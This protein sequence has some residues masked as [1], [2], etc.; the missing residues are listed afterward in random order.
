M[1]DLIKVLYKW[2][3]VFGL[4]FLNLFILFSVA[5]AIPSLLVIW[6]LNPVLFRVNPRIL[7]LSAKL[8]LLLPIRISSGLLL[9]I[10]NI[11][12]LFSF[13]LIFHLF[14]YLLILSISQLVLIASALFDGCGYSI[15]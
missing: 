13:V 9:D 10:D 11:L 2:L 5:L 4:R 6:I 14:S 8:Y 3:L 1:A 7:M 15:T 12:N